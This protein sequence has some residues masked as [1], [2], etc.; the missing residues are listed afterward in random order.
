MIEK[1]ASSSLSSPSSSGLG[2]PKSNPPSRL[3]IRVTRAPMMSI[4]VGA[5]TP[6]TKARSFRFTATRGRVAMVKPSLSRRRTSRACRSMVRVSSFQA[7]TV[8]PTSVLKP[9]SLPVKA[10]S[11]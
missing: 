1:S 11:M 7:S 3:R 2:W 10:R 8:L 4:F 5:T 6:C 9:L